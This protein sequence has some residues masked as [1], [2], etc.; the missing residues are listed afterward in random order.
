[1]ALRLFGGFGDEPALVVVLDDRQQ[2]RDQGLRMARVPLQRAHQPGMVEIRQRQVHLAA[3]ATE[4]GH[5]RGVEVFEVRQRLA[6]DVIQQA[7]V[8]RLAGD[9]Q[10][11][12]VRAILRRDHPRHVHIR[13]RR[14]MLESGMLGL[15]FQG[16]VV[17]A[18]DFQ[19]KTALLAVDAVVQV[20]LAAQ[21]LQSAAQ[22]VMLLQQ[23]KCLLRRHLRAGQTGAMNQRGE[24]HTTTPEILLGAYIA[25]A[26]G[27]TQP[28]TVGTERL[29]GRFLAQT[30]PASL[31]IMRLYPQA[32]D[33]HDSDPSPQTSLAQPGPAGT[34]PGAAALAIAASGGALLPQRIGQSEPPDPRPLRRQPAGHPAPL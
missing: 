9:I 17:A 19:D 32:L 8:D 7:H 13:V 12:Q 27:D 10:R 20:L 1:M 26:S 6:F 3:Q 11:E 24:R 2:M 16:R 22:S 29:Q 14:Q 25:T 34:V 4:T 15:Q 28:P 5:H 18:T 33:A 30:V 31:G 21:G 23:L